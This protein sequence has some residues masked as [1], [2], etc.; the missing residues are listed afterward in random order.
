MRSTKKLLIILKDEIKNDTELWQQAKFLC[1]L[2]SKLRDNDL[3]SLKEYLKVLSYI[4]DREP[5]ESKL[6]SFGGWF[7][8]LLKKP[9]IKWLNKQI[10]KL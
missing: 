6:D 4:E 9:R 3:L 1:I 2:C 7:P 8:P 10:N 5:D